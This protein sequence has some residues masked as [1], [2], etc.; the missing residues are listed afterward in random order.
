MPRLCGYVE[1]AERGC[2]IGL[3]RQ[4][5]PLGVFGGKLGRINI[6]TISKGRREKW[7][8]QI[9]ETV[10]RLQEI[11]VIWGDGKASNI[12]IDDQDNAWLIDFGG[13]W[14]EGWVDKEVA[15]SVEG[16][17]EAVNS[18]VKFLGVGRTDA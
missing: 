1:D 16:D 15:D 5:I 18:M 11:G 14:T 17:E 12:I 13:D 2:I 4:W 8:T 10:D 9:R 7:A 3:L 6:T